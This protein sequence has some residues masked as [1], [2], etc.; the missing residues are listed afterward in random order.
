MLKSYLNLH[1]PE[2]DNLL[3][4]NDLKISKRGLKKEKLLCSLLCHWLSFN[5]GCI[6]FDPKSQL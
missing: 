2:L 4:I 1:L 3:D 5:H 6:W